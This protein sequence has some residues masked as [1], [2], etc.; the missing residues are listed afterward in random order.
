MINK[1]I[2]NIIIGKPIVDDFLLFSLDKKDWEEHEK[3]Q[4]IW[5]EE[6]F[7]P[8]I[9]VTEIKAKHIDIDGNL[10]EDTINLKVFPSKT[11]LR[12]NR[13]DLVRS[14][15]KLDFE[16]IKIGKKKFWILVGN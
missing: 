2:T 13:P 15:D 5:I 1:L 10:K 3:F 6:R 4:T 12:K 7:L 8:N 11:L 9:L 16:E 14:L